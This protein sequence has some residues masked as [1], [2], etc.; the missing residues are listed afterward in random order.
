MYPSRGIL[1]ANSSLDTGLDEA[2]WRRDHHNVADRE[3][4]PMDLVLRDEISRFGSS[5]A[6]RPVLSN[7][8]VLDSGL[9]WSSPVKAVRAR[10]RNLRI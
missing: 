3:T 2:S 7:Q 8:Y 6:T 4:R 9:L 5:S 10:L 1:K